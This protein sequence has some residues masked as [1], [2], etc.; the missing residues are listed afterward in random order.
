MREKVDTFKGSR[1]QSNEIN[2]SNIC[3]L[4]VTSPG[5]ARHPLFVGSKHAFGFCQVLLATDHYRIHFIIY[6]TFSSEYTTIT[7]AILVTKPFLQTVRSPR[8]S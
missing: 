7:F 5:P 8:T 6:V 3:S 2:M 4:Q 1:N